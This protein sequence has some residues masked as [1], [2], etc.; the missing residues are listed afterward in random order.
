M[1]QPSPKSSPGDPRA[2]HDAAA[3][4]RLERSARRY[5]N[6]TLGVLALVALAVAFQYATGRAAGGAGRPVAVPLVAGLLGLTSLFIAYVAL[7]RNQTERLRADLVEQRVAMS[8]IEART[9]ELE[10]ALARLQALDEMKDS[11]LSTVAHELRT[12]L[13]AIQGYSE[14]LMTRE[15]APIETRSEF[16]GIINREARRLALLINDLQDLARLEAGRDEWRSEPHALKPLIQQAASTMAIL[17][18]ERGVTLTAE[19]PS[20]LPDVELDANRFVQ[21]LTNLVGNAVKFTPPGGRVAVDARL[22]ASGHERGGDRQPAIHLTVRDTGC[23]ISPEDLPHIFDRFYRARPSR[24]RVEGT[25]LGLAISRE[26]V[27]RIGGHLWAESVP[28]EGSAFH[29]TL[30]VSAGVVL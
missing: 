7:K 2:E 28:G 6:L 30:P 27:E 3:I 24:D 15:D 13:A 12:P 8:R 17:A 1:S 19:V 18:R 21:V 9:S 16:L 23:G 29:V 5:W 22:D 4:E 26:I 11:F 20:G 10:S 25:G 14:A